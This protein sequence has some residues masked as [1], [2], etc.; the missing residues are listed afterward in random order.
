MIQAKRRIIN[1]KNI[2]YAVIGNPEMENKKNE[3]YDYFSQKN[4]NSININQ[5]LTAKFNALASREKHYKAN[6]NDSNDNFTNYDKKSE[7]IYIDD[8]KNEE[9]RK[10]KQKKFEEL[11]Q[12]KLKKLEQKINHKRSKSKPKTIINNNNNNNN[13]PESIIAQPPN[14][15]GKLFDF[16]EKGLA[17][18]LVFFMFMDFLSVSY[19]EFIF[20]SSLLIA[21]IITWEFLIWLFM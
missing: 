1:N 21:L 5:Q 9:E 20:E 8:C 17:G 14:I 3:N 2:K 6:N 11:K 10:A 4:K 16:V 19:I 12:K 15:I 7:M 13:T 18:F